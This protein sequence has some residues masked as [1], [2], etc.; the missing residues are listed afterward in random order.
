MRST[1]RTLAL[2]CAALLTLA[3]AGCGE[4][5][6]TTSAS[7]STT[8]STSA[9]GAHGGQRMSSVALGSASRAGLRVEVAAMRDAVTFTVAE[10]GRMR[11]HPP[12]PGDNAHVMVLV[13]DAE[14]RDRLP[15]AAVTAQITGPGGAPVH[16]GPLYPMVGM[17]VGLHYGDNMR[18]AR[19]G[20]YRASIVVGPP[21][22]GRH[23]E[24]AD[25]YTKP[26]RLDVPF[27]WTAR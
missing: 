1:T 10:G 19:S 12:A 9:G 17:G 25:R 5:A 21:Q 15:D 3:T 22:V 18:L 13:S 2:G 7:G 20:R 8:S 16:N 24:L 11:K 26:V 14:S 4:D 6:P 23:P 27:A